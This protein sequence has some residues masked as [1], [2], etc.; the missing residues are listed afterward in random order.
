MT[1]SCGPRRRR[2]ET[3]GQLP[4]D[5]ARAGAGMRL[6]ADFLPGGDG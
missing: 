2:S 4:E 5:P 6:G 3:Q 1:S